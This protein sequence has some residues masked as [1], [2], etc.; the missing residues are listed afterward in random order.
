LALTEIIR[1]VYEVQ[2]VL[3]AGALTEPSKPLA[4]NSRVA[5]KVE[6]DRDAPR[7]EI[8]DVKRQDI[9]HSSGVLD[10]VRM[11]R[12]SPAYKALRKSS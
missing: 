12:I 3:D 4:L 11:S 6:D 9:S 10:E 2:L 7:Q 1:N 8:L 5:R